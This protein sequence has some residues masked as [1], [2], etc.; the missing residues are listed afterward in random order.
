ME[1]EKKNRKNI[2]N[3]FNMILEDFIQRLMII[4]GSLRKYI[5][6]ALNE[7]NGSFSGHVNYSQNFVD[8]INRIIH[9]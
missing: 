4:L 9:G 1:I 3:A 8:T 5:L 2:L 7:I 6:L